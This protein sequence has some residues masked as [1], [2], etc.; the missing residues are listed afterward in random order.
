LKIIIV[1]FNWMPFQSAGGEHYLLNLCKQLQTYGHEI[2]CIAATKEPYTY[3]GIEVY[4]IGKM[5]NIW[6]TNNDLFEWCDLIIGQLLGNAYSYNK[7]KQHKKKDINIC[8]NSS[9]HYFASNTTGI[10]YNSNHLAAL[11]LYPNNKSTV[12]QPIINY[13]DYKVSNGRKI[14]L[15]NCNQN[16][17]VYEFIELAKML[18]QVS[19]VGYKGGYGEQITPEVEN[20]EWKENGVIDWGEIGVL[21]VPSETESWSQVATEAACCGI[22]VICSDLPG[23]RENLSYAGIYINKNQLLLYKN[24]IVELMGDNQVYNFHRNLCLTRAKELDPLPRVKVLNEWVEDFI[25]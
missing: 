9:K 11:N 10:I 20:I 25:K 1:P 5:E 17:G 15:I 18:P 4:P 23:L 14:A 22:P 16:K 21:L 7:A 8:H 24:T 12:L 13:R 19:F 2:K 6:K 3:H